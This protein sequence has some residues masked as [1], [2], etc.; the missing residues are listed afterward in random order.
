MKILITGGAGFI[1][2][3]LVD[4]MLSEGHEV[5]VLDNLSSGK[6]E[7]IEHNLEKSNFVFENADLLK[8]EIDVFFEN[9]DEVWHLAANPDVKEGLKNKRNYI[10]QN[11]YSTLNVLDAM[12]KKS[13]K[14]I[15]F[16]S[17]STV[18]GNAKKIPTKE[19]YSPL[20]PISL[21]GAT[22]LA[23]EA[24]ISSYSSIYNIK[25]VVMRFANIIG[26]RSTHGIIPDFIKKLKENPQ[27]LEI[28][29]DGQQ[30]KSYLSI[31]D[32]IDAMMFL[33]K[34]EKAINET[35]NV[36]SDDQIKV[37]KIAQIVSEEMKLNP[38]FKY[39]GGRGGWKG[40]V[41]E[42][43]LDVSKLKK[44]GWKIQNNSEESIRKTVIGV[45]NS[46]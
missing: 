22:K 44:L 5:I 4:R 33:K 17:S 27:E 8:D 30:N 14:K 10:E 41:V 20:N 26:P 36:G 1:G 34:N 28:L 40:D 43:L 38:R 23:S 29:G 46:E 18:Y 7:L 3:F 13:T 6:M 31:D 32:C 2:S 45:L 24:L 19:S 15:F 42:M 25:S 39:T 12:V 11:F 37:N 35:F 9:V 21:Y 16:V